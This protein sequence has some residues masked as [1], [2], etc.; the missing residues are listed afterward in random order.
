MDDK[1]IFLKLFLCSIR[2]DLLI[3]TL[4]QWF[5]TGVAGHTQDITEITITFII[6]YVTL[7]STKKP[8]KL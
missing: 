4:K 5:S 2:N 8:V 7:K 3:I 6:L 1:T